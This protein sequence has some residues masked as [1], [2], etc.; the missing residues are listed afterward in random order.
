LRCANSISI[1]FL[2]SRR[3]VRLSQDFAIARAISRALS[4]ME[5]GTF[6]TELFGQNLD[7]N[8]HPA[9]S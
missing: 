6:R 2:R 5:R 8:A 3:D 7:F 1:F 9:Q 4:W